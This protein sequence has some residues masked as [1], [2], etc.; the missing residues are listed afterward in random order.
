[1]SA[2]RPSVAEVFVLVHC[3]GWDY[4]F[5]DGA[6]STPRFSEMKIVCGRGLT[7]P[8]GG[9]GE[10]TFSWVSG[11]A[12]MTTRLAPRRRSLGGPTFAG[13]LGL[14]GI[15]RTGSRDPKKDPRRSGIARPPRALP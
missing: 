7:E 11:C 1:M 6:G 15:G 14:Q 2:P 12:A 10:V 4:R 3:H 5:G 13:H 8:A 9:C